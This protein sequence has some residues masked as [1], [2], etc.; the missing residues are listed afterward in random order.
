MSK[1]KYEKELKEAKDQLAALKRVKASADEIELIEDE[2]KEL[3]GKINSAPASSEKKVDHSKKPSASSVKE[4]KNAGTSKKDSQ[5]KADVSRLMKGGKKKMVKLPA[6]VSK[7]ARIEKPVKKVTRSKGLSVIFDGKTYHDTDP[8]F[9]QILIKQLEER[10]LKRKETGGKVKT[11]SLSAKVGDDIAS[12]VT[13]AI[14]GAFKMHKDEI[15]DSKA[16][17]NKFLKTIIRIEN[18]ANKF[19]SEMKAILT[20]EFKQKDFDKEFK[21][22]DEVINKIKQAIKKS[23]DK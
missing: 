13:T 22:V 1:E 7:P 8:N 23:S 16:S 19:V 3:E 9:C 5:K 17:A 15:L 21:E 14:K 20:N 18:A 12:S 2:I 10:K 11:S 4:T 6:K